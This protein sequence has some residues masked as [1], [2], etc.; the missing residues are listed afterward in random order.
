MKQIFASD[1]FCGAGGFSTGLLGACADL[2][3]TVELLAVNHWPRAI[4]VHELNHPGVRHL[5]ENLDNV[6]PRKIHPGGKLDILLASPECTHHSNA[7]GGKPMS[8][9]SR[10]SAWHVVR[11]AEA[12]RIEN[13]IVENVREFQTW[14]PL[15]A[16]G[17]PIKSKKGDVF[18]AWCNALESLGYHVDFDVLN[19]ADYGAA[20]SRKRLFVVASKRRRPRWP[21]KTHGQNDHLFAPSHRAAREIIDW[22]LDGQSIFGRKKPLADRTLARIAAGLKK[23]GGVDFVMPITHS[24]GANRVGR[25]HNLDNPLPTLTCASEL[26]LCEPFLVVF[27]NNRDAASLDAP[28]S[29]ITTTGKHHALCEPFIV[30]FH[31]DSGRGEKRVYSVDEPLRTLDTSNRYGVAE[32]FITVFNGQSNSAS[33]EAPL[34]TVTTKDRFGLCQPEPVAVFERDGLTY[35]LM[36]IRFR[37]LQPHECAAAMGL[38][39]YQFTG[40]KADRMKM[41]GNAVSVECARALCRAV[42]Q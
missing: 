24:G 27:R 14:G 9:Q 26:A 15:D 13:I 22:D 10:A 2:S 23:F 41:I 40:T 4:E 1:L 7:R 12:L 42:L 34:P 16:K 36:D 35:G 20:T 18:R 19:S 6:D 5:C 29:T 8:D 3:K 32:P 25:A 17:R 33:C 30:Q 21:Q 37:M 31:D 39:D 28:L 11:W 38:D